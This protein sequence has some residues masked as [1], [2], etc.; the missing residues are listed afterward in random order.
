MDT[1][2]LTFKKVKV[3]F[4]TVKYFS[5]LSIFLAEYVGTDYIDDASTM[6]Q[7]Y[8]VDTFIDCT[9]ST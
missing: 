2:N 3:T 5:L 7:R 6:D 8:S 9:G 4:S 1:S